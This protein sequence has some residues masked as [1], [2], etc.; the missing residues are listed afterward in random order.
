MS[1]IILIF[2]EDSSG[3]RLAFEAEKYGYTPY[4]VFSKERGKCKWKNFVLDPYLDVEELDEEICKNTKVRPVSIICCIEQFAVS[5]AKYAAY[6]GINLNPVWAYETLRNKQKMKI[7]WQESGIRTAQAVFANNYKEVCEN[8][9]L[10]Y[11]LIVK[12]VYGAASAG[13][14]IV[15]SDVELQEQIR[16]ILRFNVS[17]L[18]GENASQSGFILEEYI[19][20]EEYSVDT[21]WADGKPIAYGIMSKG[22]P[23][24][25]HFP[26]RLYLTDTLLKEDTK[27]ELLTISENVASAS[28]VKSGATHIEIRVRDGKGYVIEAALRPGA[29]GFFY[30]IFEKTTGINFFEALFL[31][32]LPT[33][34]TYES[35]RLNE[36]SKQDCNPIKRMYWY[37]MGYSG[38]GKI[39][40]IIGID[41]V[42]SSNYVD[43]IFLRRKIG[44][45]ISEEGKSLAYLGWLVGTFDEELSISECLEVLNNLEKKI[46]IEY[47]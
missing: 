1:K 31:A 37:N 39:K 34:N 21:I 28:G 41:K 5:V 23:C 12:P 9:R 26:D 16:Q 27:K 14:K 7:V 30:N 43:K 47:E 25:P 4:I 17:S 19:E 3:E 20:G 29:G 10:S 8:T 40:E 45:Y 18:F 35:S 2:S 38:H 42:L 44:D 24:A 13:V 11:P 15:Y 32:S 46:D 22:I 36:I 33:K 6:I